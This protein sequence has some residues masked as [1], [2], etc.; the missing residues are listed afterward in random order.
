MIIELPS[1][2]RIAEIARQAESRTELGPIDFDNGSFS[3]CKSV[4]EQNS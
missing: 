3:K 2:D 1:E 4:L